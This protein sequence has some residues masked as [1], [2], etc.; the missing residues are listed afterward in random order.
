M[1]RK[2]DKK[3]LFYCLRKV[4]VVNIFESDRTYSPKNKLEKSPKVYHFQ[5]FLQFFDYALTIL[6]GTIFENLKHTFHQ[7]LPK[8][9]HSFIICFNHLTIISF[10]MVYEW[11]LFLPPMTVGLSEDEPFTTGTTQGCLSWPPG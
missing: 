3:G 10:H 1:R 11:P 4:E 7:F 9:E 5:N 6:K 2:V 8:L